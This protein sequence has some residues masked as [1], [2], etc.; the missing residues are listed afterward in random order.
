M[1]IKLHFQEND[2]LR[3]IHDLLH[4]VQDVSCVRDILPEGDRKARIRLISLYV[5]SE[6]ES[7]QFQLRLVDTL[8]RHTASLCC[9]LVV[10]A[11]C[12]NE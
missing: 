5:R 12:F 7:G 4:P 3:F 8:C 1:Y 11:S 2:Y 6:Y 10:V 9:I